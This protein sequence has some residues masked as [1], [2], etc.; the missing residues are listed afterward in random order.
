M[1]E[2][3]QHVLL[4]VW[5]FLSY[6]NSFNYTHQLHRFFSELFASCICAI[7]LLSSCNILIQFSDEQ[8]KVLFGGL[9]YFWNLDHILVVLYARLLRWVE[10]VMNFYD[11][12]SN[13]ASY[14]HR[15]F[16]DGRRYDVAALLVNRLGH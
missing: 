12:S 8:L 1:A 15:L 2:C 16:F 10:D 7:V 6:C 13:K 3:I 9:E 14:T 4:V 5:I 11:F